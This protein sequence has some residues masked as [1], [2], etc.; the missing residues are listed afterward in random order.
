VDCEEEF[1][2]HGFMKTNK[3]Q[4]IKYEKEGLEDSLIFRNF[5][6]KEHSFHKENRNF[7]LGE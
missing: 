7:K 5:S 6:C 3:L 4:F 1:K 2:I